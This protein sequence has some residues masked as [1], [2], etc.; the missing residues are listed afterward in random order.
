MVLEDYLELVDW[1]GRQVVTGKSR[2][3]AH[4]PPI[5]ER[6]GIESANWLPL[7]RG[8]DR[9]FHRVA[10]ASQTIVRENRWRRF[11]PGKVALLG[12]P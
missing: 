11:H 10:G 5:L 1:T 4:L 6:L 7:V 9:H 12:A 2:M 3:R 8:F